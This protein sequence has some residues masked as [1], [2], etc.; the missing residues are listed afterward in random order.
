MF[1]WCELSAE[2]GWKPV[3]LPWLMFVEEK[4]THPAEHYAL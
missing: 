1:C 2:Y 3:I 4:V